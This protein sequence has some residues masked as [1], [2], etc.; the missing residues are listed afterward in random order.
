MKIQKIIQLLKKQV[1]VK[2]LYL[3]IAANNQ[4]QNQKIMIIQKN[5]IVIKVINKNKKIIIIVVVQIIVII[6]KNQKIQNKIQKFQ[7]SLK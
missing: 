2:T 6:N 4:I 1:K 7:K 3:K 5:K